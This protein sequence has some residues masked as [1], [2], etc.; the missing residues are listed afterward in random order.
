MARRQKNRATAATPETRLTPPRLEPGNEDGC[1]TLYV[2]RRRAVGLQAWRRCSEWD[3]AAL[4]GTDDG[5]I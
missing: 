3:C 5:E 2:E 4:L 1:S